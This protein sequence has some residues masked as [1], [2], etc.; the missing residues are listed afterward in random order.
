MEGALLRCIVVLEPDPNPVMNVGYA[1]PSRAYTAVLRNRL[2]RLMREAFAR[3]Q[4][5]LEEALRGRGVSASIIF[6]FKAQP[7]SQVRR[8]KLQPVREEIADLCC[9]LRH[10][11]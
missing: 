4:E 8:L 6:A 5:T 1:V 3:E 2:R 7:Q 11:L 9:R 10:T